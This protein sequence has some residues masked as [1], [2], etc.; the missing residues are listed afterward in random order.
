MDEIKCD[1]NKPC[2]ACQSEGTC[3]NSQKEEH[4]RQRLKRRLFQIRRKVMVMSGK[5]GVGKSTVAINLAAGLALRGRTVGI[6]D[7]DIHGPN[8]PRMLGIDNLF[9]TGYAGG[10]E[11]VEVFKGFKA[12]SMALFGQDPDK[13]IVWR[14]PLKHAAIKQFLADV[15]WGD[16]DYLF[17]D[18]PP[19]T[20]DE[21]LSVAHL[22]ENVAGA[23]IVTTPQE[24]AL[25]DSRKAVDFSR[26]L[27]VPVLGIVENMSGMICPQCGASIDLFKIGGGEKAARE[28]RV[29]FLGRI[30]I[31]PLVVAQCDSGQ[32][33]IGTASESKAKEAFIHLIDK[34]HAALEPIAQKADAG[35]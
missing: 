30:P 23:I 26:Q 11:P 22:I 8:V 18:L 33:L 34:V 27:R 28:L 2:E 5:G 13:A 20:G 25:L 24:V 31:D 17:I 7:A 19:G 1:T 6:L 35:T 29:P 10:V 16:L 3:S 12:V 32:P 9:L 14:G 4:E 21:P 15:N